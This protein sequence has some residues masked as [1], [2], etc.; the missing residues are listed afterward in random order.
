MKISE[1]VDDLL[2]IKE[3]YGDIEVTTME[4]LPLDGIY[5]FDGQ[6]IID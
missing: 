5:E 1:L 6:V 3:E 2:S 4:G